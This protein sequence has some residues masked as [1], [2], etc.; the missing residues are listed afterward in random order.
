MI[1][2]MGTQKPRTSEG[3]EQNV[4]RIGIPIQTMTSKPRL[5]S[6]FLASMLIWMTMANVAVL[7]ESRVQMGQGYSDFANCY[8]AGTLVRRGQGAKLYDYDAQWKVQQEFASEVKIRRAP[9]RY[10]RPP[11][12]ALLFSAFAIWPYPKAIL[13]WTGFKLV[14][15]SAIPFVVVRG[16]QWKESFPI[17]LTPLLVPGTF[18][19]FMDILLGQDAMLLA[20]LFAVA[21]WE[22]E[23]GWDIG[24]GVTL[25]LALFKFQFVLPVV[26]ILWIAGRKRVLLGFA[27]SVCAVVAVS[28]RIVGWRNLLRYPGYLLALNQS[29]GVGIAPQLQITLRGLLTLFVGRSP[30]PGRVHWVL[31]PIAIGAIVYTGLLW[32]KAGDRFLAEGFGLSSIVGIVTSYYAYSYDLLLLIVP[33]LAMRSRPYDAAKGDRLTRYLE[34]AGLLPLLFTPTIWFAKDLHSQ[35][36]MTLPLLALAVALARRLGQAGGQEADLRRSSAVS[37]A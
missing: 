21:F 31:A 20:F 18:S 2:N 25:G 19:G 9:L 17:W 24:A 30:Y 22:L 26:L 7:W 36:L 5:R 14:L 33:L 32:R 6:W 1:R 37:T 10:L 3:D 29:T 35:C 28:A 13:L 27:P 15:L 16:R 4:G 34:A 23:T 12:E 8:T 11:Y